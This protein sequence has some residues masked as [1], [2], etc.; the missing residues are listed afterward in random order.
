MYVSRH[1]RATWQSG[2][3]GW[4]HGSIYIYL[5]TFECSV[6]L[7][8]N[9][10]FCIY[11]LGYGQKKNKTKTKNKNGNQKTQHRKI[12]TTSYCTL[13][14]GNIFLSF[15]G[16][17][18]TSMWHHYIGSAGVWKLYRFWG[19]GLR[20]RPLLSAT[21]N[22]KKHSLHYTKVTASIQ[23]RD[24]HIFRSFMVYNLLSR[25]AL[26]WDG[27]NECVPIAPHLSPILE[28]VP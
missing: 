17:L 7:L 10:F 3:S 14:A 13:Q 23:L 1:L 16:W 21:F 15:V 12:H 5:G 6:G 4:V 22:T 20:S 25:C 2:W 19:T 28:K 27:A 24:V 8:L 11:I 26:K 9:H 18:V